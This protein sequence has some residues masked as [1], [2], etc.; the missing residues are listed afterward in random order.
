MKKL[1]I[2]FCLAFLLINIVTPASEHTDV[3]LYLQA[4]QYEKEGLYK[5]ALEA[6]NKLLK[7][8]KSATIY[9][10]V[11]NIEYALGDMKA[12]YETLSSAIKHFP[13]NEELAFQ[14][15]AFCTA[16]GEANSSNI[17][18]ET[19]WYKL[20]AGHFDS[21][22]K[23][24]RS[25]T[26]ILAV[27]MIS[28]R[29]KEYEKAIEGYTIL[30]DEFDRYEFIRS[31]GVLYAY[32]NKKKEAA[33]DFKK[34][35]ERWDDTSALVHLA[36]LYIKDNDTDNATK[37]LLIIAEKHPDYA[38]PDLFLGD[39][40]SSKQDYERTVR[41]YMQAASNMKGRAKQAVLKYVGAMAFQK[42]DYETAQT[43]YGIALADNKT[44]PQLFYMAGISAA[45]IDN[46]TAAA[47]AIFDEGLQL[48]PDYTI[49][50]LRSAIN[51][52][53]AEEYPKVIAVLEKIDP[54]ERDVQ[55]YFLMG[56]AYIETKKYDEG[57]EILKKGLQDYPENVELMQTLAFNLANA[58]RNEECI[59]VLKD[60]LKIEPGSA[61]LQNFLGYLYA[62]MN[63]NLDE[64]EILIDKAL[65]QEPENYAYLDSKGWLLF[66]RGKL[67]EA[68]VY[69]RRADTLHPGDPEITEHIKA[70]EAAKK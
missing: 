12:A 38:L 49:L 17:E 21:A 4:S 65:A 5:E 37:Y 53:I 30:I 60:A 56:T 32:T 44:D 46:N 20:A 55:F 29:L 26:N 31:R 40:Y 33:D 23:I 34:A 41:H 58:E 52:I 59:E 15:G 64:A 35:Y 2:F 45:A 42:T 51:L 10:R 54:I 47:Q 9:L 22:L 16:I 13:E 25:E 11:A 70:I 8:E 62:D 28:E 39:I 66:R 24:E 18:E 69:I 6:Y 19:R 43:A 63:I 27:A 57:V 36:D 3:A 50:R 1:S 67:K 7:K 14:I 68:E 61:S 48:F